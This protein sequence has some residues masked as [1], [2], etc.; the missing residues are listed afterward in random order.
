MLLL[1]SSLRLTTRRLAA[2]RGSQRRG[3]L[4]LG[5]RLGL[6]LIHR[7]AR[8]PAAMVG[9]KQRRG[10][11]LLRLHLLAPLPGCQAGLPTP[12]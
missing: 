8:L 10:A 7:M 12:L 5:L 9:L 2:P 6:L 1:H 3:G 4:R 11:G